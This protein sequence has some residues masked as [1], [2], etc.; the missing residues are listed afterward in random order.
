MYRNKRSIIMI[1]KNCVN[2]KINGSSDFISKEEA[3]N[4]KESFFNISVR[5]EL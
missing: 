5:G 4:E 1:K 3:I 2:K